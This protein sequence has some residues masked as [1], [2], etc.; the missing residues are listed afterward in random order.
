METEKLYGLAK[1]MNVR[2]DFGNLPENKSLSLKYNNKYFVAL[3]V[4]LQKKSS[5]EKVCLAHELGHCETDSFYN[6]YSPLDIRE[7]HEYK[8]DKWAAQKLV[9]ESEIRKAAKNGICDIP[10]L[11]EHFGV[12]EEF[13]R[14][15]LFIYTGNIAFKTA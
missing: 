1:T 4:S 15:A 13:M 14:R 8:A 6:I 11:S 9:P 2:L 5:E 10:S 7:K 12:T 3:D